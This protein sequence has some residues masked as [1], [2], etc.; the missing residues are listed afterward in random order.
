MILTGVGRLTRDPE[1]KVSGETS[2]A[3][4]TLA[5]DYGFGEKKRTEF[6]NMVVFGKRATAITNYCGKGD[7]LYVIAD[8]N[9]Y[10]SEK[11]G[12]KNYYTSYIVND[13]RLLGGAK[14]KEPEKADEE[15]G[16]GFIPF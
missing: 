11:D 8:P 7:L 5:V 12:K 6:L 9:T 1:T 14:K 16:D 10:V 4:F 2:I 13:F 15:V 3:K